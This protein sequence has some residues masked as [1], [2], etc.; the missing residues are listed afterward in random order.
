VGIRV[1]RAAGSLRGTLGLLPI[2]GNNRRRLSQ[3]AGD[4]TIPIRTTKEV[5]DQEEKARV[6]LHFYTALIAESIPR[7]LGW[8]VASILLARDKRI[9]RR[10]WNSYRS[11]WKAVEKAT[12]PDWQTKQER[13]I[14]VQGAPAIA[15]RAGAV[16]K[17]DVWLEDRRQE[18]AAR[19]KVAA[20]LALREGAIKW[21][22]RKIRR[23]DRELD[24]VERIVDTEDVPY[25]RGLARRAHEA[26]Y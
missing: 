21:G 1:R 14:V 18:V 2:L 16:I 13:V 12:A 17:W 19:R 25:A 15:R 4:K 24:N 7:R 22:I 11:T 8:D 10:V 9:A 6:Q 5:F 23:L 3:I 26:G 20:G